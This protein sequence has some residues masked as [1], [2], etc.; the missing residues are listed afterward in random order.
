[1]IGVHQQDP[2]DG[3]IDRCQG[4]GGRAPVSKVRSGYLGTRK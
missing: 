2:L 3:L 4:D 1:M